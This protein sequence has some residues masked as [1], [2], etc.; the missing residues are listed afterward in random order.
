[1][2]RLILGILIGIV[3]ISFNSN[4]QN[5]K[6]NPNLILNKN[7]NFVLQLDTNKKG[8][9]IIIVDENGDIDT[10]SFNTKKNKKSKKNKNEDYL[11]FDLLSNGYL[12][13]GS[14]ELPASAEFMELDYAKSIGVNFTKAY[15]ARL[16]A[17]WFR[18]IYG[19]GFEIA[20]FRL[21]NDGI[22]NINNDTLF[23][24]P[25][26]VADGKLN[27]NKF[28][29][30]YFH[31]PL[32]LHFKLNP[33]SDKDAFHIAAGVEGAYRINSKTKIK[34]TENGN[35]KKEKN[36]DQFDLSPFKYSAIARIGF[37][38]FS[39]FGRYSLSSMFQKDFNPELSQVSVGIALTGF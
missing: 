32:M 34:Y 38:N 37:E 29:V 14:F 6:A 2:K 39:I 28:V 26:D 20:N 21:K 16:G 5:L 3:S 22:I 25:F 10:I 11:F 27:K 13:D 12:S 24:M 33:N 31:V 8:K 18:L 17:D 1:M 4:A 30:S 15:S 23:S 9:T 7:D 35:K 19:F 36:K